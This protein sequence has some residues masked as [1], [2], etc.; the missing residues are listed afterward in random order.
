MSTMLT[1][2]ATAL[3]TISAIKEG[4][5]QSFTAKYNASVA[6]AQ[7][8]AIGVSSAFESQTLKKQSEV[9]QAQIARQKV[10]TLGTQRATYAAAGV[11]LEEGS[12]LAVMADT[13]TQYELD[14]STSRYNLATGLETIRYNAQTQQAQLAA[15]S[16]YQKQLAKSYRTASYLKAGT[17]LLLGLSSATSGGG[18][19]GGGSGNQLTMSGFK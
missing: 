2:A 11:R 17:S 18:G 13:A 12:P 5:Q 16:Q 9:E 19:G 10:K 14:L 15:E 8:E 1:L 4:Q 7:A 6:E 3:Q